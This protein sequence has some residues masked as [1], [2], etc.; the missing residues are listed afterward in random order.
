MQALIS[1]IAFYLLVALSPGHAVAQAPADADVTL[2]RAR[3]ARLVEGDLDGALALYESV[4]KSASAN[5]SQVA[6]ALVEMGDAYR[7]L[8]SG[9]AVT[10]YERVLT[11]FTDQPD[12]FLRA[13]A[14]LNSLAA[15][16]SESAGA[17]DS[18]RQHELVMPTLPPFQERQARTYD[19]APDGELLAIHAPTIDERKVKFPKLF[20][21]VYLQDIHGNLR[22]PV[23][24]D[25]GD[26][27][28]INF[29]RFSPDGK[30]LLLTAYASTDS[31][32]RR[33]YL[34]HN[35]ASGETRALG[36]QI[37]SDAHSTINPRGIQWLPDSEGFI[38]LAHDG[39][40][41][42]GLDGKLQRHFERS[43]D[44]MT[45]LG[46]VSADGRKLLFHRQ[47]KGKESHDEMDI[48]L[49]DLAS[50]EERA[51]TAEAGF[52]GWPTWGPNSADFYYVSGPRNARNVYRRQFGSDDSAVQVTAYTNASAIYPL[53]LS[54]KGQL[55][56]SLMKDNHTVFIDENGE[57]GDPRAL[58]RG[59]KPMPGPDGEHIHYL[60]TEPGREGVWV[61]AKDG[62]AGQQVVTGMIPT[63]YGPK[64]L[65]SPDGSLIAY[66][67][68]LDKETALFVRSA[69]GGAERKIYSTPGMR[70]LIPAWAPD[71]S[72]I[73]FAVGG[74]LMLIAPDG[75][76]PKVLAQS[77]QWEPWSIE[78][79]PD[80]TRLAAFGYLEGKSN[81]HVVV[82]DLDTGE[83]RQATP[84]TEDQYKEILAW[85]PDG[86]RISY[87]YYNTDDGNGSRILDL[88]T[89]EV[90][91]LVDMPDPMW[92]YIGTWGPDQRYYFISTVRG[93]GNLWGL[94]AFDGK[95]G[96][97]ET[98]RKPAGRSVSLPQWSRDGSIMVWS[99]TEQIRQMW[100][101]TGHD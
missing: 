85:H 70:H 81:N 5:R 38:I 10:T 52:E 21:E 49:L 36:L 100:M 60:D 22:R 92:D 87:M 32:A 9:Q 65:V 24:A 59:S 34:L 39:F 50:G 78:W 2:E 94:Y 13:S 63:S 23:V 37:P 80:G 67:R 54:D 29:P 72:E 16:G 12:S 43:V 26:W 83:M 4:A 18:D 7:M 73:A 58:V 57:D 68:H 19:F 99:E 17:V 27:E 82:I 44:H 71:S 11:E 93:M 96:E 53:V 35:L 79:A 41:Q 15:A 69:R 51:L 40:W 66:A 101:I 45:R 62:T 95:S 47:T 74:K 1:L 46:G 75:D 86:E 48:W 30:S 28:F 61:V 77:K 84:D 88:D 20:R 98:V 55:V 90:T 6:R 33:Q 64:S 42:Y 89:G 14:G 31:G 97:Y 3:H 91:D 56:F 8:D 25:A 76:Q